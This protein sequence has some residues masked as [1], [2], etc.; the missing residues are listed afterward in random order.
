MPELAAEGSW[1]LQSQPQSFFAQ[2]VSGCFAAASN[3]D[4]RARHW[5]HEAASLASTRLPL[6]WCDHVAFLSTCSLPTDVL[7]NIYRTIDNEHAASC[8]NN[9][10]TCACNRPDNLLK[11]KRQ[12]ELCMHDWSAWSQHRI[13]HDRHEHHLGSCLGSRPQSLTGLGRR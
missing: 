6:P 1:V 5:R 4:S 11:A 3:E 7:L 9:I 10:H 8:M 2:V 13:S 12:Q